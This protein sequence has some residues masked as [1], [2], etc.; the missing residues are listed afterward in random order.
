M[1][2]DLIKQIVVIELVLTLKETNLFSIKETILA[3]KRV[4]VKSQLQLISHQKGNLNT[5]ETCQ[6]LEVLEPKKVKIAFSKIV[7]QI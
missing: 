1:E 4:A 5:K 7:N 3:M 6:N 2:I